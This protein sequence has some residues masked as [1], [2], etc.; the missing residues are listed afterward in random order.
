MFLELC[1]AAQPQQPKKIP[2]VGFLTLIPNPDS[3]ELIFLHSLHELGYDEGR[4]ITIEYRRAAGKGESLPQL[5]EELVQLA[6]VGKFEELEAAFSTMN[7]ERA[8]ALIIQPLF[9]SNLGQ[10]PKIADLALKNRLPTI[11]DGGGFAERGGLL[12]YGPDQK[13]MF[14]RAATFVDKIL[15]GTKPGDLPV[16]QPMK[17][18]F[19]INL[20]AAKQIGLTISPNVLARA[21][22]VIK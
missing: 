11:Y 1:F 3:L 6:V 16:E 18:E 4:N 14:Q 8:E 7:R 15:K 9:I 10:D 20:K 13:P 5:P 22:R 21:D 19:V 12:F 2:R 17:F